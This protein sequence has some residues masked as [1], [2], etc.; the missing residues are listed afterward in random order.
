MKKRNGQKNLMHLS[1]DRKWS[2]SDKLGF[3]N[4][5]SSLIL[6]LAS[7][8][9]GYMVYHLTVVINDS[10]QKSLMVDRYEENSRNTNDLILNVMELA[11][12]CS[13]HLGNNVSDTLKTEAYINEL[14]DIQDIYKNCLRNS[15]VTDNDT[16][17]K[18]F[19]ES[20]AEIMKYK[21]QVAKLHHEYV[22]VENDS[23]KVWTKTLNSLLIK[24]THFTL[25]YVGREKKNFLDSTVRYIKNKEWHF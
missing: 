18:L 11:S 1:E 5:V 3:V 10:A 16:C 15:I 22:P 20:Y 6:G 19:S 23:F 4:F 24:S 9:V 17:C 2:L 12:F 21:L 14:N 13:L 25:Q 7:F 8:V